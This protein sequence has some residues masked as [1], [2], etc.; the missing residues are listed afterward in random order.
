MNYIF[1]D[2]GFE[3]GN[4]SYNHGSLT[5]ADYDAAVKEI[6]AVND[7]IEQNLGVRP[8]YFRGGGFSQGTEMWKVVG[9]QGMVAI[10]CLAGFGDYSGGEATVD[11]IIAKLKSG[12]LDGAILCM[13]STNSKGVTPD[14]LAIALPELY[15]QG[16][17]F[18]TVS[19]LMAFKGVTFENAPKDVYVKK[20]E[21]TQ[22]GRVIFN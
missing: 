2:N 10:N 14:A 15:S 17:R 6:V 16:Y 12:I 21:I 19:E 1:L 9:E 11:G 13:H 5:D 7:M 18:C 22:G 20:F 4:H 3:V 8:K